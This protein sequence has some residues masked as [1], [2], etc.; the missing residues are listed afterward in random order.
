MVQ[1]LIQIWI[2]IIIIIIISALELPLLDISF[3]DLLLLRL[4]TA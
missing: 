3:F 4:K 2:I 1:K